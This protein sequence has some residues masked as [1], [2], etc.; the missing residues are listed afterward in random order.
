[1]SF[2]SL[3]P[4]LLN[5][6]IEVEGK[7]NSLFAVGPVIMSFVIP[8]NSNIG[9][10]AKKLFAWSR[11]AQQICRGFEVYELITCASKDVQVLV[12]LGS[13]QVLFAPAS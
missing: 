13:L 5:V 11:Q 6:N 2:V 4:S 1:M 3:R 10:I 7:Q 12:S 9:K 8:P